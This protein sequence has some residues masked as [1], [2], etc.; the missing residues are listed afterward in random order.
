MD[1]GLRLVAILSVLGQ[2]GVESS[3]LL[4]VAGVRG[5]LTFE[6]QLLS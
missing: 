1:V 5:V 6:G 2:E 3:G 4:A